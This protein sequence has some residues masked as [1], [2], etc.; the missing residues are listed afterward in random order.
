[1]LK[2]IAPSLVIMSSAMHLFCCGIPL[3]LGVTGLTA[4]FG[5]SV[6][7][8][9]DIE[10]FEAYEKQLLILSGVILCITVIA[11]VISG[12]LNCYEDAG[13]C[14]EPCDNKKSFSR[15]VLTTAC[16]LYSTSILLHISA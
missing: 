15:Y 7:G 13:C 16:V 6:A 10:W 12:K 8:A 14:D 2:L 5:I 3:L 1:M 4:S 9:F 11:H